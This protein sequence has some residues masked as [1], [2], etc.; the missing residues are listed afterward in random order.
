MEVF[1]KPGSILEAQ[2]NAHFVDFQFGASDGIYCIT[3]GGVLCSFSAARM[4]EKWVRLETTSAYS[5]A[6]LTREKSMLLIM[7]C[8]DGVIR[9]FNSDLTLHASLPLPYPLADGNY[10]ACYAVSLL[11]DTN[12]LAAIYAD[13]Q[14][15]VWDVSSEDLPSSSQ[16]RYFRHHSSCVWDLCFKHQGSHENAS[17][18]SDQAALVTCSQDHSIKVWGMETK[19]LKSSPLSGSSNGYLSSIDLDIEEDL[20]ASHANDTFTRFSLSDGFPDGELPEKSPYSS[21]PRCLAVHPS[22][23]TIAC[24]D[25][26]GRLHIFDQSHRRTLMLQAHSSEVLA[27]CFSPVMGQS[28]DGQWSIE[29]GSGMDTQLVLLASGGRDR[30]IHIFNAIDGFS[31][32]TTLDHHSSSVT[33][34]KFTSDGKR[35]ISCSGDRTIVFSSVEGLRIAKLKAVTS[36]HGSINGLS[37]DPINK[38]AVTS[39]QDKRLNIWNIQTGKHV[40]AYK[41]DS[42]AGELHRCD[43]DPSGKAPLAGRPSHYVI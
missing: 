29:T 17:D 16:F 4:M 1:G 33:A 10:P 5:I 39:G 24:G 27:I 9:V 36:P 8:S 12:K 18:S 37:V 26:N 28:A 14:L 32:V 42:I 22:E 2:R 11:S 20:A 15:I 19:H 25:R 23:G 41:H 43:I 35:L 31:L 40:R 7:G 21:A 38:F 34:I 30:L 6:L 13:R 3:A